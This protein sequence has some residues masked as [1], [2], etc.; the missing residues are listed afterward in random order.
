M[1]FIPNKYLIGLF[2]CVVSTYSFGQ[3]KKDTTEVK[4]DKYVNNIIVK[5]YLSD[6]AY[7]SKRPTSRVLTDKNLALKRALDLAIKIYGKRDIKRERPY[8]VDFI[9]DF[10]IVRGSLKKGWVGGTFLVIIDSRND[11]IVTVTHGK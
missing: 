4:I 6:S 9:N 10:Y 2:I 1:N 11:S 3:S 8:M 5:R 7:N